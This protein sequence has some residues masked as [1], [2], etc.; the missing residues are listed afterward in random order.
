MLILVSWIIN[1]VKFMIESFLLLQIRAFWTVETSQFKSIKREFLFS[2]EHVIFR[3]IKWLAFN[4][5]KTDWI[6]HLLLLNQGKKI[7]EIEQ[8]NFLWTFLKSSLIS[9]NCLNLLSLVKSVL[10]NLILLWGFQTPVALIM[11]PVTTN[12][13]TVTGQFNMEVSMIFYL[14]PPYL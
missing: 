4:C 2:L 7:W 12:W 11:S 1:Y 6:F 13:A 9:I 5:L 10:F 8:L 3:N 14:K